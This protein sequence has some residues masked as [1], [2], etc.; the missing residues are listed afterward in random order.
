MDLLWGQLQSPMFRAYLQI[1][2]AL[3]TD[4]E[5][6]VVV[7]P[8]MADA[9]NRWTAMLGEVIAS[10]DTAQSE[11]LSRIVLSALAGAAT[12]NASLG[13]PPADPDRLEFRRSLK[14]LIAG[15]R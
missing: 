6:A 14:R 9:T 15:A 12:T 3:A 7:R 8:A 13:P 4:P 2:S 10:G 11:Q 1:R 5:L